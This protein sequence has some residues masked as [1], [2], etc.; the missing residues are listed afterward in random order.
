MS[1]CEGLGCGHGWVLFKR[2][3]TSRTIPFL[4]TP[5]RLHSFTHSFTAV[6]AVSALYT[7]VPPKRFRNDMWRV[8]TLTHRTRYSTSIGSSY[9]TPP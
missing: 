9:S 4:T 2:S 1:V 5:A 6:L 8:A 7:P 3:S